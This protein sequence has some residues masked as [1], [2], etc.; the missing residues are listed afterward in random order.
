MKIDLGN[1]AAMVENGSCSF[2]KAE[3][4]GMQLLG[5]CIAA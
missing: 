2:G 5:L 3:K 1:K 4:S